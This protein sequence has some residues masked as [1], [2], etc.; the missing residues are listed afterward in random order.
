MSATQYFPA[1]PLDLREAR[2]G[3][4]GVVTESGKFPCG[5]WIRWLLVSALTA[6]QFPQATGSHRVQGMQGAVIDR[7]PSPL[8]RFPVYFGCSMTLPSLLL[9]MLAIELNRNRR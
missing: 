6:G 8:I 9:L 3:V 5:N 2:N 4:A 1:L 7:F